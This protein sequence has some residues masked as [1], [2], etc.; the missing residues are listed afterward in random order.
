M[1]PKTFLFVSAFQATMKKDIPVGFD[2][3][4][5][6][7][8]HYK[9]LLL[10]HKRDSFLSTPCNV[11]QYMKQLIKCLMWCIKWVNYSF[12]SDYSAFSK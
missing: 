12:E 10:H 9:L 7:P 5:P 4:N 8:I 1:R 6:P 2:R 11:K 3:M